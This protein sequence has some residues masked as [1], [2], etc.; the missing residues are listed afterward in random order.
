MA[1]KKSDFYAFISYSRK[2]IK[3]AKWIHT[4][5]E[6]FHIPTRLPRAPEAEPIPNPLRC[7]RDVN[8][9]D[10]MP[11]SFVKGIEN[12]LGSSKYLI[13]I[14]SP[15]SARSTA[16]GNHYVD[17]EVQEFIKI[18]GLEYAKDHILPVI[19]EGEISHNTKD[20]E[21]FTPTLYTLGDDFLSHNFPILDYGEDN[22]LGKDAK[23]DF[24]LKILS[25]ILQV[26]YSVL[27][28]RYQKAQRKRRHIILGAALALVAVLS[29]FL[30]FSTYEW[31]EANKNLAYSNYVQANMLFEAGET[32]QAL[33]YYKKSLQM[34]DNPAVRNKVYNLLTNNSWLVEKENIENKAALSDSIADY[35]K[36]N[37]ICEKLNL[38]DKWFTPDS[39]SNGSLQGL[40]QDEKIAVVTDTENNLK[41]INIESRRILYQAK[42]KRNYKFR[43][44]FKFL[45]YS[46][47][48][49]SSLFCYTQL[50]EDDN[51]YIFTF[52]NLLNMQT[53]FINVKHKIYEWALSPDG[54]FLVYST[55]IVSNVAELTVYD[56]SKKQVKWVRRESIPRNKIIFSPD[57]IHFA[58]VGSIIFSDEKASA[59]V[60]EN[61]YHEG[62]SLTADVNGTVDTVVFSHDGRK[63]AVASSRNELYIFNTRDVSEAV[64]PRLFDK[65]IS[66]LAF[67]P[68]DNSLVIRFADKAVKEYEIRDNT[69][70]SGLIRTIKG[71][72][73][74]RSSTL[75][76][77]KYLCQLYEDNDLMFLD[78]QNINDSQDSIICPVSGILSKEERI[79]F[80]EK[81]QD[82][83]YIFL[84]TD[85]GRDS[86]KGGSLFI[87]ALNFNKKQYAPDYLTY[88]RT[89]NFPYPVVEV[90][91]INNQLIV[92]CEGTAGKKVEDNV[93]KLELKADNEAQ[94]QA[95]P[96]GTCI[97]FALSSKGAFYTLSREGSSDYYLKKW[98]IKGKKAKWTCSFKDTYLSIFKPQLC[99]D[100]NDNIYLA[101]VSSAD[102]EI[103]CYNSHGKLKK[104]LHA[105]ADISGLIPGNS[106]NSLAVLTG[107]YGKITNFEVLDVNTDNSLFKASY[108]SGNNVRIQKLAFSNDDTVIHVCGDLADKQM[109]GS[110]INPGFYDVWDISLSSK[111]DTALPASVSGIDNFD[112]CSDGKTLLHFSNGSVVKYVF[113]NAKKA[114]NELKN[115]SVYQLIGGW[116]LN[117]HNIPKLENEKKVHKG[118]IY[119]WLTAPQDERLVNPLSTQK[120]YDAF[121]YPRTLLIVENEKVLDVE[122]DNADALNQ[123]PRNIAEKIAE[124]NF[125]RKFTINSSSDERAVNHNWIDSWWR[126]Q[127]E[128]LSKD[129]EA[130]KAYL[131]YINNYI[132]KHP[133]SAEP[134][135]LLEQYY[136]NKG[137]IKTADRI[138]EENE[139]LHP[140]SMA[141][142]FKQLKRAS[143]YEEEASLF[144]DIL[145]A[146]EST[147]NYSADDLISLYEYFRNVLGKFVSF[148][149]V[150][151][152]SEKCLSIIK[153]YY[154]KDS[155]KYCTQAQNAF[156][157]LTYMIKFSQGGLAFYGQ[158]VQKFYEGL[159]KKQK[160]MLKLETNIICYKMMDSIVQNDTKYIPSVISRKNFAK[161]DIQT[162]SA[163]EVSVLGNVYMYYA[164]TNDP[165]KD[166]LLEKLLQLDDERGIARFSTGLL[167]NVRMYK[168][169]GLEDFCPKED[170]EKALKTAESIIA[171]GI[172]NNA[173]P[174]TYGLTIKSVYNKGQA[175]KLGLA[176]GDIL[177]IYD[178]YPLLIGKDFFEYD[179]AACANKENKETVELV[180]L[181][182]NNVYYLEV[183]EGWLGVELK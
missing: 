146:M 159:T 78:I 47:S 177:L 132:E 118:K 112:L 62:D 169:L 96:V 53:Y 122:A 113:E 119:N 35:N 4:S 101:L 69:Q 106:G 28:D 31:K 145:N 149:L 19:I 21:C 45:E 29:V 77:E 168:I 170:K 97:S 152:V 26:K 141:I 22:T 116:T 17:W 176:H 92:F 143:S 30:A 114:D 123:Y 140:Y 15:N 11:E 41:L 5:L 154:I 109:D 65:K 179:M 121:L 82:E 151:E 39:E 3:S 166:V 137:D 130:L 51:D 32:S 91:M 87:F 75:I 117:K 60:I 59:T 83:K 43:S 50:S 162:L 99:V 171:W 163:S 111:F 49:D 88:I 76:K 63:V 105:S 68:S 40:S 158:C 102:N 165:Q 54:Q 34:K 133:D 183:E 16:D 157:N 108:D 85:N 128:T 174:D 66:D 46:F 107:E 115:G 156:S 8:D 24:I 70:S 172:N 144:L 25:F 124:K 44:D 52:V 14:C 33:A 10:V 37:E 129:E 72:G 20:N 120:L 74:V 136:R 48:K 12:A 80:F 84:G 161:M 56:T 150:K 23:N 2:D 18:H 98:K 147:D 90:K 73:Y 81:S 103:M 164:K 1:D 58:T 153:G 100:K 181:R 160:E 71:K 55:Y 9:L 135:F 94:P 13:V 180:V 95:L 139:K 167:S 57:S 89:V 93:Y 173:D 86:D 7:F 125:N 42:P 104:K 67:A 134:L 142:H 6:K 79:T 36:T 131:F 27:N 38:V 182:D 126:N 138:A 175:K 61:C 178:N 64:K 110:S 148:D 127:F 155:E